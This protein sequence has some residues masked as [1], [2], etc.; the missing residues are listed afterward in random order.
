MANQPLTADLP[1]ELEIGSL[2]TIRVAAVNPSTGATVSGVTIT[3][4]V[5]TGAVPEGSDVTTVDVTVPKVD[6]NYFA[7]EDMA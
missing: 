7:S 4:M 2:A 6:P 3:N 5:I 1:F